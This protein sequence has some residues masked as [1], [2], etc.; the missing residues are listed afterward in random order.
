M[1]GKAMIA[2][3]LGIAA[4][5]VMV[6]MTPAVAQQPA[7]TTPPPADR[8]GV[9]TVDV[10]QMKVKVEKVDL[11]TRK[12]TVRTEK[13]ETVTLNAGPEVRNL[14]QVRPGDDLLIRQYE[15][16]A[17][18]VRKSSEP[19]QT[20]QTTSVEVAP[21]GEIPKGVIVETTEITASVEDIEYD[22][23]ML[24]L[25]GPMGNVR[26]IK[27]DPAVTRLNEVKKG[28]EVVLRYTEAVAIEVLRP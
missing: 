9:V 1:N 26:R 24:T 12:V 2:G 23:R 6:P 10:V 25:K 11:E 21:R 16:L 18:F 4:I 8:P 14:D 15:A 17:L 20:V 7:V 22:T 13:G 3:A 5:A 28:D 27:V 19:P